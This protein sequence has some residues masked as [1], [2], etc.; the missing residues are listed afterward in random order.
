M[1][2]WETSSLKGQTEGENPV[3]GAE[4]KDLEEY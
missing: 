2:S 1:E 4:G 3:K